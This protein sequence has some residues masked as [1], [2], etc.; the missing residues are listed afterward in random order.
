MICAGAEEGKDACKG[1]GGSPLVCQ[2]VSGRW[3]VVGMVS[4]GIGCGEA[5]RP[6]VYTNVHEYLDFI[7]SLIGPCSDGNW[8]KKDAGRNPN[9]S[10]PGE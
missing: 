2:A 7:Y 4:W 1:D 10:C 9:V 6:A 3:H 5:E 8:Y